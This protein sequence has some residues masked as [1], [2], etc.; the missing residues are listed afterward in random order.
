MIVK[1]IDTGVVCSW[2]MDFPFTTVVCCTR[3]EYLV[4]EYMVSNYIS[5]DHGVHKTD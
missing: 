3:A 5:N 2:D 1:E 4:S